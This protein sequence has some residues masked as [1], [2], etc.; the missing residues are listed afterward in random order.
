[1]HMNIMF[2]FLLRESIRPSLRGKRRKRGSTAPSKFMLRFLICSVS[3]PLLLLFPF[4]FLLLLLL[5]LLS[6]P[7]LSFLFLPF[8]SLILFSHYFFFSYLSS[9]FLP[10]F[11]FSIFFLSLFLLSISGILCSSA[12]HTALH[13]S[14][15]SVSLSKSRRS[16]DS[17][18]RFAHAFMFS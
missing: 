18:Q 12:Y 1:M 9:S 4:S 6:F 15:T 14:F 7:N 8:F 3:L 16:F 13:P 2:Y 5:F 10:I 17:E 11:C